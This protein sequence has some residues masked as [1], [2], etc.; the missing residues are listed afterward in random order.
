MAGLDDFIAALEAAKPH[1]DAASVEV[2]RGCAE[3]D[4]VADFLAA[5]EVRERAAMVSGAA[6]KGRE[7]TNAI[8]VAKAA[9]DEAIAAAKRAKGEGGLTPAPAASAG[10]G[11]APTRPESGWDSAPDL[12]ASRDAMPRLGEI[13]PGRR[14]HILNGDFD[15]RS[16]GHR[17]DSQVPRASKFP[18]DWDDDK[19]LDA[20]SDVA[21][22]PDY[23]PSTRERGGWI[24]EGTR[25][26]V[27]IRVVVNRDGSV[28][29]GHPLRGLGV[30][31]NPR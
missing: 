12:A 23:P 16:G 20:I 31:R 4:Q 19:I 11:P 17:W 18:R 10:P 15:G 14:S 29:T 8:A 28:W 3:G 22:S 21:K 24:C 6:D 1:L 26:G 25:D 9:L 30:E 5:A 27:T 13:T 2:E 7:G